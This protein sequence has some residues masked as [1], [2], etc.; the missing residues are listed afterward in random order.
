MVIDISH[1]VAPQAIDEGAYLLRAS[2]PYFPLGT[3]HVAVV[4]PAVGTGRRAIA[5]ETERATFVGP[6]NGVLAA[7]LWGQRILT[8][9]ELTNRQ[10]LPSSV[11]ATF[12][13]RDIF[14]PMAAHISRG[15]PLTKLGPPATDLVPCPWSLAARDHQGV[16]RGQ[17]VHVDR[18]G[19]LITNIANALA[20]DFA[21]EGRLAL[22]VEGAEVRQYA[23][24]FEAIQGGE[25]AAVP[26]SCGMLQVAVRGGSA[27]EALGVSRGATLVLRLV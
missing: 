20:Q 15:V 19:N 12:H 9:V 3:V 27:S 13:G 14:A 16:V 23:E 25:P 22:S 7:A 6:D 2:S 5:I 1:E 18:F 17:V 11:S 26:G 21:A 4:D 8:S 24:T 10:F